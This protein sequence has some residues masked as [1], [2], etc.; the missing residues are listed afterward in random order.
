MHEAKE[1][2][3]DGN[4]YGK[5]MVGVLVRWVRLS[6]E[7]ALAFNTAQSGCESRPLGV[8]LRW[9]ECMTRVQK[10]S[11]RQIQANYHDERSFIT[12][13]LLREGALGPWKN[14]K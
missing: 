7:R 1:L 13:S 10:W 9:G 6:G 8:E 5:G 2:D 4:L 12:Q 14:S 3:I 11:H